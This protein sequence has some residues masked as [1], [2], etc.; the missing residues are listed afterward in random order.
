MDRQ[1]E[2]LATHT[3]D[4][5]VKL[6]IALGPG[7]LESVYGILLVA[8]LERRGLRVE[9]NLRLPLEFEGVVVKNALRLDLLVERRLV[10]ELKSVEVLAPVHFKQLLTYLRLMQLPLG[11]L[12]NFGAATMKEGI[13]R[14]ANER[15]PFAPSRLRVS[16][17]AE[18]AR[19]E[20]GRPGL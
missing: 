10:V 13:H 17:S 11:I 15:G 3:I 19:E 12:L 2:G 18:A 16:R 8:A 4:A 9:R 14:V 6:H 20:E 1:L 5:A 7:L